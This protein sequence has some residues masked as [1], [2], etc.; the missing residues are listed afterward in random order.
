MCCEVVYIRTDGVPYEPH[1]NCLRFPFWLNHVSHMTYLHLKT[2]S[3]V[4]V[5]WPSSAR[6]RP[7]RASNAANGIW[8]HTAFH[9][10]CSNGPILCLLHSHFS[11]PR[12]HILSALSTN[13]H[14]LLA[15][16]LLYSPVKM[17]T[18]RAKGGASSVS[19]SSSSS[20]P[21]PRPFWLIPPFTCYGVHALTQHQKPGTQSAKEKP[22]AKAKTTPKKTNGVSKPKPKPKPKTKPKAVSK[23]TT[24]PEAEPKPK[25]TAKKL[26]KIKADEKKRREQEQEQEKEK[27][28]IDL[29]DDDSIDDLEPVVGVQT[30]NPKLPLVIPGLDPYPLPPIPHNPR[31]KPLS[32]PSDKRT[33]DPAQS[34]KHC[35]HCCQNWKGECHNN[36][37]RHASPSNWPFVRPALKPPFWLVAHYI[38]LTAWRARGLLTETLRAER[39]ERTGCKGLAP[40]RAKWTDDI[41]DGVLARPETLGEFRDR[42]K[43]VREMIRKYRGVVRQGVSVR[44]DYEWCAA[45]FDRGMEIY[46]VRVA[47]EDNDGF[48]RDMVELLFVRRQK[49][50]EGAGD[51]PSVVVDPFPVPYSIKV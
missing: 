16:R 34:P 15:T 12:I 13:S 23:T 46:G 33:P 30:T 26:A 9:V 31:Y 4:S 41:G 32:Q 43:V 25:I 37:H 39:I 18:T 14:A 11:P 51:V 2:Q 47:E 3:V 35:P 28:T 5:N 24:K 10:C 42:P 27:L 1:P 8:T 45:W 20:S 6:F 19:S 21:I 49:R 48:E 38:T 50:G 29:T 17:A 22:K 40:Q 7:A 36:L 44:E